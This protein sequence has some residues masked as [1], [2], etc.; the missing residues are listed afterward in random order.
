[1]TWSLSLGARFTLH[2][3]KKKLVS[4]LQSQL[5]FFCVNK[6]INPHINQQRGA[7]GGGHES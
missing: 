6:K 1:M 5:F 7:G 3:Y 2:A 4:C